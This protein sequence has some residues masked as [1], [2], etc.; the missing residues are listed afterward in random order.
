MESEDLVSYSEEWMI[1]ET[2]N[3]TDINSN[4]ELSKMGII[5]HEL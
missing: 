5:C 3:L 1:L 4:G 2:E